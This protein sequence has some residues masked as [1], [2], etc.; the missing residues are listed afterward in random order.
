MYTRSCAVVLGPGRMGAEININTYLLLF[1][2]VC[3]LWPGRSKHPI[4]GVFKPG[5]AKEGFR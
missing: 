1:H 4:P 2:G 3:S 5:I